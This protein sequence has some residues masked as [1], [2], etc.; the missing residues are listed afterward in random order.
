[1]PKSSDA[2]SHLRRITHGATLS[3]TAATQPLERQG[4][5]CLNHEEAPRRHRLSVATTALLLFAV[6]AAAVGQVMLKHGMQIAL[7]PVRPSPAARSQSARLP[8]R[9]CCSDW[10]FSASRRWPGS[11]RCP[12]CR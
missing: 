3:T 7:S 8:R 5:G 9:G 2:G 11:S 6:T 4:T 10:W 12:G 1:M